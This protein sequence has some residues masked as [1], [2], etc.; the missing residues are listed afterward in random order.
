[1]EHTDR[2]LHQVFQFVV[3]SPFHSLGFCSVVAVACIAY[4]IECMD[5]IIGADVFVC[6]PDSIGWCQPRNMEG[7]TTEILLSSHVVPYAPPFVWL[8]VVNGNI[9]SNRT[10]N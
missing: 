9:Q 8:G 2:V 1:M 7:E 4:A 3:D 10:E 6:I 5:R